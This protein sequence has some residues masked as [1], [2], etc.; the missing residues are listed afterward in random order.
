MNDE[1]SW[2]YMQTQVYKT[3]VYT[4]LRRSTVSIFTHI[5]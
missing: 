1:I 2:V 4:K 3:Q 5:K